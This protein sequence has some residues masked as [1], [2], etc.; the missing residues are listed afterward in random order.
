M[1][2]ASLLA[3]LKGREKQ[4][5]VA[6]ITLSEHGNIGA[7]ISSVSIVWLHTQRLFLDGII[8]KGMA[9]L[10]DVC[11]GIQERNNNSPSEAMIHLFAFALIICYIAFW[12][13]T[14]EDIWHLCTFSCRR[15]RHQS[16]YSMHGNLRWWH[17]W[18]QIPLYRSFPFFFF[19]FF[20]IPSSGVF[21]SYNTFARRLS[22]LKA[23]LEHV[24]KAFLHSW[25]V[26]C[27]LSLFCLFAHL[28]VIIIHVDCIDM[29]QKKR[30]E[31]KKKKSWLTSEG[32]VSLYLEHC[33]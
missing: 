21:V 15:L 26:I 7:D 29:S 6:F 8:P 9:L 17:S 1:F 31:K 23:T 3:L 16:R 2:Q 30:K 19:F 25:F 18:Y 20:R 4:E 28:A 5:G 11:V 27:F 22:G 12:Q 33:Y 32:K 24:W 10:G 13:H 14:R